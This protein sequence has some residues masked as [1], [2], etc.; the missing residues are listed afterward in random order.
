MKAFKVYDMDRMGYDGGVKY[1]R[2]QRDAERDFYDRVRNNIKHLPLASK[3]DF[4]GG[5]PWKITNKHWINGNVILAASFN[6]WEDSWTDCGTEYDIERNE[7]FLE[8]IEV[9]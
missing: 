1:Y 2:R 3:N 6:Y 7:I 9:M 5:R 4:D 8:V